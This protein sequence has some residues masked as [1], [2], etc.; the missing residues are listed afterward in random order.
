MRKAAKSQ[1]SRS[2]AVWRPI[3]IALAGLAL[4]AVIVFYAAAY[5]WLG[6]H[7]GPGVVSESA[8]PAGIVAARTD[9][10]R[11]AAE[12]VGAERAR[13]ILFGDLHVHTTVSG[14]AFFLSLPMLEGEGAH[15]QADA[16]DFARYCSALD[17]WSINDHAEFL[18]GR[19]W[20]ETIDSI[21]QCNAI[22]TDA[23][24]PDVV[25]FLGW[26]WT[27]RGDTP[28]THYGHKNVVLKHTDDARIPHR[29]IGSASSPGGLGG[30]PPTARLALILANR[31]RRTLD[32][33]RYIQDLADQESC[34][35]GVPVRD[36]PP[37][38]LES[39]ATPGALFAKLTDWGHESIVIPHGTAWGFTAPRGASFDAQLSAEQHDPA[40]QTLVE[41]YSGHGNS[42]EYRRFRGVLIGEKGERSCPEPSTEYLPSCWQAGEIIRARCLSSGESE[43]ECEV[44]AA[45]ARRLHLEAG[46]S[47]HL[48]VPGARAEDW[49]DAG[50]CR[51]C[52]LP[53]FD[54]RPRMSVQYMMALR[55]PEEG[56]A[57]QR[58]RFGFMASS[59]VHTARPGTGYKEYDRREMTEATGPSADFPSFLLPEPQEPLARSQPVDVSRLT[60]FARRDAERNVSFLSTGGLIAVHAEA[61]DRDAIWSAFQRREV[62]GTSGGRTLLWFDLTNP[63]QGDSAP[64]GSAVTMGRAPSFRVR[65][66]GALEQ[67]PGCPEY[68]TTALSPERLHHLCRDECYNPSDR[69]KRITRIE[70]IR[71]RPQ[72]DAK[73]AVEE[74]IEDPWRIFP[75]DGEAA[76]CEISFSDSEFPEAA[77]DAL[78]YVR[79]IEE[80]S[81]AVNAANLR[82]EYDA[83]GSCVRVDPCYGSSL[84]T[85]YQ[86]DCLAPVEERAWSS[87]I[88]VDF[89]R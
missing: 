11:A 33:A 45:E 87:P 41:V 71:I 34:P 62:Y 36:L 76:G 37:D 50:Q 53:A 15:P 27:Q 77:R 85:P 79:A 63:P 73:E 40:L 3:L 42:E 51:D 60:G 38:C 82:C 49:V 83:E 1:R 20:R 32:L 29:P 52:F 69:R 43:K 81:R 26:E 84:G 13:Q 67:L 68:A 19:H 74:L 22:A 25:A 47:G 14:D 64:M 35:D 58:F 65:A 8:I 21:R 80:P 28:A 24:H 70:V 54:Y 10:R 78:Y 31:D 6:R 16:C 7:E 46:Q 39:A 48:T 61:R 30:I 55:N 9:A 57:T 89:R 23:D 4:L 72:T 66:V 59:D 86:D 2:G 18:T 12:R 44:R 88:F 56:E 75:C 5:G 17:F